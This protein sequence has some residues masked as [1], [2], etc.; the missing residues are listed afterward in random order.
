MNVPVAQ[1]ELLSIW[2]AGGGGYGEPLERPVEQV[3]EDIKD[4]YVSIAAAEASYGVALREIDRRAL[5]CEVD[6]A[7]TRRLRERLRGERAR[8]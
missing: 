2:T 7:A 8:G 1:G 5:R 4:D 6:E 3:I